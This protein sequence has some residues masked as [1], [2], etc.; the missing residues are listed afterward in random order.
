MSLYSQKDSN[1]RKTFLLF[2]VFLVVIIG[3][4]WIFSRVYANPLILF[5]AVI[6]SVFTSFVSY[7]Y[8]DKIVLKI[9]RAVPVKQE[10]NRELYHIVENLSITAGL[11]MP[12]IYLINE[13]AMNAF[14]TG[15]DQQHAVVAVTRGLLE[16]LNKAELEGVISHELSHIGNRD[17]LLS[18]VVVV[19]VGFVALLSDFFMRSMFWRGVGSRDDRGGGNQGGAIMIIIGIAMAVLSPIAVTLIQL[20]I[21]RSR[22]FLADADGALLT[23][24]PE[25]LIS[26][27]QKISADP[28]PLK[29]ANKATNH[30]W[31]ATPTKTKV[32][33]WF[34]THPPIEERIA[35]LR[36]MNL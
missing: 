27:L 36:S 15:R 14:A 23:R 6:F 4:G 33:G 8:S 24:Y 22:E 3:L 10:D 20:A 9:S 21:S 5:I 16:K 13:P 7:W 34:M 1:I 19:L 12:R 29:V 31:I 25:G 17:I 11:A 30:L 18:T 32:A 35:K 26:A 28:T 2:A